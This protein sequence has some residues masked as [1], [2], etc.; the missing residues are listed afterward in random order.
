VSSST[1]NVVAT[2]STPVQGSQAD[3]LADT[4]KVYQLNLL[5]P[6]AGDYIITTTYLDT[7]TL[8]RNNAGVTG[9]PFT[10]GGGLLN[11]T[12]NSADTTYYY[13]FYNML[14]KSA[15]CASTVRKAVTVV[16]P[17]ITLTGTNTLNSNFATGNQWYENSK[18]IS[19]ATGQTLTA[20]S[21]GNY[22]LV[23]TLA[24]GCTD[25]TN[26]V[27]VTSGLSLYPVP[28]DNI[29][30]VAFTADAST[31]MN[32]QLINSIGEIAY[33]TKQSIPAG[34]FSTVLNIATVPAGVYVFRLT[35]G[36]KVTTQKIVIIR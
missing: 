13:Y 32:I 22:N 6:A 5:I 10:T 15:G 30:N 2:S 1:I 9:Y 35:L 27:Y 36:T 19:G 16:R 8:Y 17:T 21:S 34:K 18:L 25:S 24:T 12:G 31:D 33:T 4:G 20:L 7:A 23:V 29:L 26:Y 11:I 3:N 14:V 28:A